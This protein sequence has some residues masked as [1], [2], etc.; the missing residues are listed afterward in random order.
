MDKNCLKTII[1]ALEDSLESR[2]DNLKSA[3]KLGY[4]VI[5]KQME[6]KI[7]DLEYA[8]NEVKHMI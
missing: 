4:T 1:Q 5:A 2:R 8:L 7:K 3:K 6:Y